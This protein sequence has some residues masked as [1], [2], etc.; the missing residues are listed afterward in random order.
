MTTTTKERVAYFNGE[1]VPESEATVSINDRGFLYGDVSPENR[2]ALSA[3]LALG[4]K[5]D[6]RRWGF[7]L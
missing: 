4:S 1:I 7:K 6:S 3:T 5:I 2:L